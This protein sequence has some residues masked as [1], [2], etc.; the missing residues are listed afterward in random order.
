MPRVPILTGP[1]VRTRPLNVP[2]VTAASEGMD[3]A[4]GFQ[5]AAGALGNI[6]EIA[7]RADKAV[8]QNAEVG[9]ARTVD[10]IFVN[11]A[12]NGFL[13]LKGTA[14]RDAYQ[15]LGEQFDKAESEA[16]KDLNPRQ[17]QIF[18]Q[19]AARSRVAAMRRA[20]DYLDRELKTLEDTNS[21]ALQQTAFSRI[22]L[23]AA[24]PALVQTY[25]Q[26][27]TDRAAEDAKRAG[28]DTPARDALVAEAR[29]TARY[30]QIASLVDNDQIDQ[31]SKMLEVYG[32]EL[33][34]PQQRSRAKALVEQESIRVKSQKEADRIIAEA[35]QDERAALAKVREL[36]GTMR[37]NVEQ[38]IT[39]YYNQ[40]SQLKKQ[41]Q[42]NALDAVS[43]Q[44]ERTGNL[45]FLRG[46]QLRRMQEIPGAM[47]ALQA[48]AKQLQKGVGG[49]TGAGGVGMGGEDWALYARLIQDA[50][51]N[52]EALIGVNPAE[53]RPFLGD[54]EFKWFVAARA[55]AIAGNT[56]GARIAGQSE[57]TVQQLTLDIGRAVKMFPDNKNPSSFKGEDLRRYN[58]VQARVRQRIEE[59]EVKGPISPSEKRRIAQQSVAEQAQL[60]MGKGS[61]EVRA[62]VQTMMAPQAFNPAS[63][64]EDQRLP[65]QAWAQVIAR[66]GGV[67]SFDKI[68]RMQQ[69]VFRMQSPSYT[70]MDRDAEFRRIALEP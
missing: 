13:Q 24:D 44:L 2:E 38:R 37:D 9:Y 22:A 34:D 61:D 42:S 66:Y 59:A 32:D 6:A 15:K 56:D 21:K 30:T 46:E 64:P 14:V 39:T 25:M 1:S 7:D 63:V 16:M 29:S 17:R 20:D 12:Q 57:A 23:D 53:V 54:T 55:K 28:L 36:S 3:I 41:E 50:E 47:Q 51:T 40:Q 65:V 4:A 26:E 60:M 58:L 45:N 70:D 8:V 48:R 27:I 43:T 5:A 19:T 67:P 68:R 31:A 62:G 35:G 11:E 18:Q 33:T 49:G 52:P 69:V 10:Q